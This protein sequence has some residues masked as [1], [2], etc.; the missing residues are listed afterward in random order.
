MEGLFKLSHVRAQNCCGIG[1]KS[2][3]CSEDLQ[4]CFA[5]MSLLEIPGG[6]HFMVNFHCE[7]QVSKCFTNSALNLDTCFS[8]MR[9]RYGALHTLGTLV[10]H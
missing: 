9:S 10:A 3:G 2:W 5:D 4:V 7:L 1:I 8:A 6:S